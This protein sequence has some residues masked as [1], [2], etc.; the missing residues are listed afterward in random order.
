MQPT[1]TLPGLLLQYS[2][3]TR[4]NILG[5][6][7]YYEKSIQKT[8]YYLNHCLCGEVKDL[9]LDLYNTTIRDLTRSIMLQMLVF[10]LY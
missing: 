3:Q 8:S 6:Q 7:L 1:R 5:F 9:P 2:S 10:V 4:Y